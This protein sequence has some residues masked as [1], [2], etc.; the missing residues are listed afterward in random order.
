LTTP[1]LIGYMNG[2]AALVDN[3]LS[4]CSGGFG[5]GSSIAPAA[6]FAMPMYCGAP[7]EA[8]RM[9]S[10]GLLTYEHTSRAGA[11]DVVAELAL[12]LTAG[13]EPAAVREYWETSQIQYVNIA[14][15]KPATASSVY[16]ANSVASQVT[17]GITDVGLYHSAGP[18]NEWLRVDL[19][20]MTDIDSVRVWHR[21]DCCQTRINGATVMIA[22]TPD[23]PGAGVQCGAPLVHTGHPTS[24]LSCP[25]VS[26]RYVTVLSGNSFLQVL[27]LQVLAMKANGLGDTTCGPLPPPPCPTCSSLSWPMV[28]GLS[29]VCAE[30]DAG[31]SCAAAE[32]YAGTGGA[33][34]VCASVGARLCS[35]TELRAGAGTGTGCGHDARFVWSSSNSAQGLSCADTEMV[36]V[37]GN[38]I[39]APTCLSKTATAS[40]RCCADTECAATVI[41]PGTTPDCSGVTALADD[42][43]C[44]ALG[45]M[46]T[47]ALPVEPTP[48][49][50]DMLPN[51]IKLFTFSPEY[52]AT[53]MNTL[54]EQPRAAIPEIPTQN[55]PYKAIIVVFL[56]GGADSF[57]MLIPH[58]GCV[59]DLYAEYAEVRSNIALPLSQ[60]LPMELHEDNTQPCTT[61]ATHPALSMV[62]TLWDAG[63]ASWYANI[64]TLVEPVTREQWFSRSVD[65]P[66]LLFGHDSMQRQCQSVHADNTGASGVL[67]RIMDVLTSQATPYR[68]K[69]YSMYGIRKLVEGDVPPAVIGG[70]GV[71]RFSQHAALG[72][73][74][75]EMTG[76]ESES[77]F[78]DT[79]AGILESSLVDTERLGALMADVSLLGSYGGHTGMANIARIMALPHSVHE[80]ERDVFMVG[81][82]T[83]DA[84][85]NPP[86]MDINMLLG[87]LNTDLIALHTDLVALN[88]WDCMTMVTISDFGR[89]ITSNGIGTDH[90]WGGNNFIVGGAVK[91]RRIHGQFP[92]DI[93]PETSELEIGR[94]RGV[95]IPTTPWEGMWYGL[96]QWFGVEDDRIFEVVP[97]AANFPDSALHS[98]GE[99]FN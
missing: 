88:L 89:T 12:L 92:D 19:G 80:S 47:P 9:T 7:L 29:D 48:S 66:P 99:V 68:S 87:K 44:V 76:K 60:I 79:Y 4:G 52:T 93:K 25:G 73:T 81:I 40:V 72:E 36:V 63:Q 22:E 1:F 14:L 24:T 34:D 41:E 39:G 67:G 90:A 10:E 83:F 70:G 35:F 69:V 42:A 56:E 78:A 27:E 71:V 96:A 16:N 61:F 58:S 53:N 49:V 37:R 11:G 17:D 3:G 74:I 21:T 85:Q 20:A 86:H 94:G 50:S 30:S 84:H 64:G 97:N 57:N 13:R 46:Y 55:R 5:T 8:R 77:L 2:M 62:K 32:T 15:G 98:V 59:R 75:R 91:G 28:G 26:G 31:F 65:V 43:A 38:N 54:R 6:Q 18:S 23:A 95:F 33:V 45:C 82:R 51:L